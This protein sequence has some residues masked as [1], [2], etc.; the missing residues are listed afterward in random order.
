MKVTYS[1]ELFEGQSA[2]RVLLSQ[3]ETVSLERAARLVLERANLPFASLDDLFRRVELPPDA[4]NNLARSG[5]LSSFGSR[6]EVLW[7]LGRLQKLA[8]KRQIDQLAFRWTRFWGTEL[9][10]VAQQ[11]YPAKARERRKGKMPLE[12]ILFLS[13]CDTTKWMMI[14]GK[15]SETKRSQ[16]G[17]HHERETH[18]SGII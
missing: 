11:D 5:A 10:L 18:R 16:P 9:R 1:L 7:H 3:I 14:E 4:W 12:Q 8:P 2:I 17:H 6:R 13:R 15:S